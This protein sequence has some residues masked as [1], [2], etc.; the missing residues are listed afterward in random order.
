MNPASRKGRIL[1]LVWVLAFIAILPAIFWR[2][3][4]PPLSGA[5]LNTVI[6]AAYL[7]ALGICYGVYRVEL[8]NLSRQQAFSLAFLVFLLTGITNTLHYFN[9]DRA[10]NYFTA[11]SNTGW[12][13]AI[14]NLVLLHAPSI[15]PHSYRFLPN[16]IVRWMELGGIG[17]EAGRD[18]YRLIFGLLLYYALY[19][20]ARLYT[21]YSGAILSMVLVAVVYPLS[22][23]FY[24]G[25]LTDPLS[26]LSFVLALIFLEAGDFPFLFT[27][28]IIGSLA[29]ET[30]LAMA[31]YYLL[32][33]WREKNYP[34][35]ALVLS[36]GGA[37]V[38]IAVRLAVVRGSF[39]YSRI[40]DVTLDH[41]WSNASWRSEIW[42][43]N[44]WL[45]LFLPTACAFLP[46]LAVGWKETPLSLKR[47][48]LFLLPVLFI[49]SLMFSWLHETRNFMPVV[50]VSAVVAARYLTHHAAD[51]PGEPGAVTGTSEG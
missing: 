42:G 35:K 38:L 20:Y 1:L 10:S 8:R 6:A 7:L 26:H 19:R 18:I 25:Q 44:V 50:F 39:E 37:V 43:K 23:E 21:T 11:L 49:S 14:Q 3:L 40:S 24:A 36:M 9:V 51:G 22:F 34:L 16:S 17:Y 27:T 31:G 29:K 32:F 5:A 15:A 13:Q 30:V 46:F 28:L 47:Q 45:R 4:P 2:P 48:I 12:Q 41:I 33:H